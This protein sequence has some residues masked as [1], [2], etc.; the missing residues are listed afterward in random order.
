MKTN[1][2][3]HSK[4]KELFFPERGNEEGELPA[5]VAHFTS[6]FWV[7]HIFMSESNK[8]R[9]AVTF[10]LTHDKKMLA[11]FFWSQAEKDA[12]KEVKDAKLKAARAKHMLDTK[13]ERE[14]KHADKLKAAKRQKTLRAKV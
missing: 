7:A 12:L 8:H 10:A 6:V 4:L 1:G 9:K 11:P 14:K 2:A 3:K 5:R 13:D